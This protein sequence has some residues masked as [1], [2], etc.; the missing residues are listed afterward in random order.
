MQ[1][2]V[3]CSWR[4][5][6]SRYVVDWSSHEFC[7]PLVP[8]KNVPRVSNIFLARPSLP[9]GETL[10]S[11]SPIQHLKATCDGKIWLRK[12][13]PMLP[14]AM[15]WLARTRLMQPSESF[16]H[17]S[18]HTLNSQSRKVNHFTVFMA[19][20]VQCKLNITNR[21]QTKVPWNNC[22]SQV[23]QKTTLKSVNSKFSLFLSMR[24]SKQQNTSY[25]G[26]RTSDVALVLPAV[27]PP[28]V[29]RQTHKHKHHC[30]CCPAL[31][32]IGN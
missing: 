1:K 18:H 5:N 19:D 15:N 6:V 22:S 14:G 29:S 2:W 8:M 24:S 16:D 23:S 32:L 12:Y 28:H 27:V 17:I 20:L 25:P 10:S 3:C 31:H 26:Q 13:R 30:D 21:T 9:N 7:R 11:T 4:K